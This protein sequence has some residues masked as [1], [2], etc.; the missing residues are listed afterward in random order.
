M[1]GVVTDARQRDKVR[2]RLEEVHESLQLQLKIHQSTVENVQQLEETVWPPLG[3]SRSRPAGPR[4]LCHGRQQ[5]GAPAQPSRHQHGRV[6]AA[7]QPKP[8]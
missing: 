3:S 6:S 7:P 2:R 4:C 1:A 8:S 5:A